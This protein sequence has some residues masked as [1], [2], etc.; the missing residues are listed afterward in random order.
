MPTATVSTR[1]DRWL[2]TVLRAGVPAVS[3]RVYVDDKA[4]E[5]VT[6]PYVQYSLLSGFAKMEVAGARFLTEFVYIVQAIAESNTFAS[7][8]AA[9]DQIYTTLHRASGNATGIYVGSSICEE[10]IRRAEAN[11]GEPR[12]RYLGWRVRLLC[13]AT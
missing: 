7:V 10:E 1:L 9:S 4:P 6:F 13:E 3:N 2:D 11:P 12:R 8:E 5:N